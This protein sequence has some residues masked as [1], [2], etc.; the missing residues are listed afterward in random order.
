MAPSYKVVDKSNFIKVGYFS[1]V[2]FRGEELRGKICI[3]RWLYITLVE[4]L[5]GAELI[6]NLVITGSVHPHDNIKK[7]D[8][9]H[10]GNELH[11]NLHI[12]SGFV[13]NVL[14]QQILNLLYYKYYQKYLI[15]EPVGDVWT[16]DDSGVVDCTR[17][18]FRARKVIF[19]Q[20]IALRRVYDFSWLV[21]N[22]LID[23]V[24]YLITTDIQ[25]VLV[26]AAI[27]EAIRRAIKI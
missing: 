2:F 5:V 15:L 3:L 10:Y 6:E 21:I 7:K 17:T 14:R 8:S 22:L 1:M 4:I 19:Y 9:D 26:S 18:R 11:L 23:T 24:V 20:F 25:L 13:T 27:V 16:D 12:P